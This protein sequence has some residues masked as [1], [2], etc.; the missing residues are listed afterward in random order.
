MNVI[1]WQD[2]HEVAPKFEFKIMTNLTSVIKYDFL[3]LLHI[4]LTVYA[5]VTAIA[6]FF[7]WLISHVRTNVTRAVVCRKIIIQR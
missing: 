6:K 1:Q 2:K 7:P 5:T 3:K 4:I